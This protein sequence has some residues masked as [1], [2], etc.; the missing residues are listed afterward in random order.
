MSRHLLSSMLLNFTIFTINICIFHVLIMLFYM[1]SY[2]A[3]LIL[4]HLTKQLLALIAE[5]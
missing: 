5:I 3:N 1:S 4:N 2:D